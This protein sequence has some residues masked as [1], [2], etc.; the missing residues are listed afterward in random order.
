MSG[1]RVLLT[2]VEVVAVVSM[3]CLASNFE[4]ASCSVEDVVD[5]SDSE[6]D[7]D[8]FRSTLASFY[9]LGTIEHFVEFIRTND[10]LVCEFPF[11][12]ELVKIGAKVV[13]LLGYIG[14]GRN[15]TGHASYS[16]FAILLLGFLGWNG[17]LKLL[18]CIAFEGQCIE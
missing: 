9:E 17:L 3:L 18:L 4:R 1:D 6:P 10:L 16:S 2:F 11:Q 7:I 12:V 13:S 5:S 15:I 14:E 8:S